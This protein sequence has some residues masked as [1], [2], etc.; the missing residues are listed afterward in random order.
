MFAG[1]KKYNLDEDIKI[2]AAKNEAEPI[3]CAKKYFIAASVSWLDD[4]EVIRGIIERRF[5]SILA[6]IIIQLFL[7]KAII[8]DIPKVDRN[9]REK[10]YVE[11]IKIEE[12]LNL[13]Y[14]N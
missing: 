4:V 11:S 1:N 12:E 14:Q 2:T 3:A 8:V 10:G 5:N 13:L 7:D 9:R 6:H